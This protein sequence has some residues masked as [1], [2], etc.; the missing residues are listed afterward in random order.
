MKIRDY[1]AT[2]LTF[3]VAHLLAGA[4]CVAVIQLDLLRTGGAGLTRGSS[5]YIAVLH[6]AALIVALGIDYSKQNPFY[7]RMR[8]IAVAPDPLDLLPSLPEGRTAEQTITSQLARSAYSHHTS[9]LLTRD[10]RSQFHIDFTNR[11]AHAMKTPVSVID[12]L[13]QQS[14]ETISLEEARAFQ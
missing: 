5:I 11:W 14:R 3:I 7:R 6:L 12:L 9:E 8:E 10:E 13:V 1:L 2:R 4:L